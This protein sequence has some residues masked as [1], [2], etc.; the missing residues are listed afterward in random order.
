MRLP[1]I[2]LTAEEM[3]SLIAFCQNSSMEADLESYN[4]ESFA[5]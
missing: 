3:R 4:R 1:R 2:V 5:S